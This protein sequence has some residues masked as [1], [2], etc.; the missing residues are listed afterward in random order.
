MTLPH[1]GDLAWSGPVMERIARLVG[2]RTGLVFSQARRRS[3]ETTIR[4]HASRAGYRDLTRFAD[5]LQVDTSAVDWLASE[6]TIGE[7]YFFRDA[8]QF[9]LLRADILPA[10]AA[11][12]R[13]LRMW[14]AGCASGEEPYSLAILCAEL[15]LAGRVSILGTDISRERL[16]RA[17]I[18]RY[19]RW[20]LRGVPD[21]VICTYFTRRDTR[22][23]LA[24]AIRDLVKFQYMNLAELDAASTPAQMDLVLCRNVLIYLD[25]ATIA[26]L[27]QSLL[28][29]LA[30]GGWLLLGASDPPIHEYGECDVV[31]T[32]AGL[33]YRHAGAT[34]RRRLRLHSS[35]EHRVV[36]AAPPRI[37]PTAVATPASGSPQ[38]TPAP[39]RPPTPDPMLELL[40]RAVDAHARRREREAAELAGTYLARGG[41]ALPA[42]IIRVRALANEGALHEAGRNCAAA[43]ER[44]PLSA[45]LNY[46]QAVLLLAAERFPEALQSARR[47]LY[48]D[49]TLAMASIAM[50]DALSRL[51]RRDEA[52]RAYRSAMRALAPLAPEGLVPA[53]GGE[54]VSRVTSTV[55]ARLA[56]TADAS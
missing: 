23:D 30:L 38:S 39:V 24:P 8:A 19:S 20:S 50:G 36:H 6:L 46:L 32:P 15:G 41:D 40:A 11:T 33:V 45:E 1:L 31:I 35:G 22:Y 51:Q 26:R 43:L 55:A 3:V 52:A 27:A 49:H 17:R 56:L 44:H 29:S 28:A 7:T 14:S 13:P 48:L 5:A 10:L 16:A 53:S 21:D 37:P 2:D 18:G 42:W 47:A 12:G 34:R 54:R 25:V 4:R 9:D